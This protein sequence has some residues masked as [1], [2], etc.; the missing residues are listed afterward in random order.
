M[1]YTF[2]AI[3]LV[4]SGLG[5]EGSP[6]NKSEGLKSLHGIRSIIMN[7]EMMTARERVIRAINHEPID[8]MPIDLGSHM[9][10]GISM[11]AYWNLRK[12]LGLSTDRIWIPDM[13]QCLAYVDID[14]L[15]RFHC[16]CILLEPSFPQTA[17]WNARGKYTFT[18]PTQANPQPTADG[19]WLI[20]KGDQSMRMLADD[21]FFNGDWLSDWGSG[22]EDE[23]V[24][25]YARE[26]ERIYKETAY[27]TNLVGYSHGLG[28]SNY[29]A[30]SIDDAM[31]AYDD[32]A[33]LHERREKSLT[34]S[35]ERMGKIIDSFGQYIQLVT[36]GDDMGTQNGPMCS[37]RYIE[38]FCIPYYKRFCKFVH[39]NSDIKV[40]L[41]NCGS[42]KSLI[43]ML[44]DAGIDVLNPVQISA[45]NMDPQEL[46]SEFGNKL[47]FWGGGCNTQLVLGA[48]RPEDVA[49]NVRDLVRT[50]KKNSGFVF[51]QVHNI[52]GNV[53]PENIVAM[54]DT[55][56]EESFYEAKQNR[57]DLSNKADACGA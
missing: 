46:K 57:T 28:L 12:Y 50:F 26:A 5:E 53:P 34:K 2:R 41:H 7:Q 9:S 38:E 39:A 36:M 52:M 32:P 13:V 14:I 18:I 16:D 51:N 8:R 17:Q 25:L 44:I 42:V 10:T 4:P 30:G 1:K 37:P 54:L 27:A 31:F 35:I 49:S 15:E 33:G 56:Y 55:A 43:P 21:Y 22:T 3:P 24:A 6:N 45:Q 11:F 20:S 48:G 19:G 40:F 47:C 29:G 23:R